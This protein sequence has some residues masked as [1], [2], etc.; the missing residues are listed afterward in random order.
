MAVQ[1]WIRAARGWIRA[2]TGIA[3]SWTIPPRAMALD[4]DV[5]ARRRTWTVGFAQATGHRA[6]T[7]VSG[8]GYSRGRS[9][10]PREPWKPCPYRDST[11]G[12]PD[13][14]ASATGVHLPATERPAM[15]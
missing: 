9:V 14:G 5:Q 12:C 15:S 6:G 7:D 8:A 1:G 3:G 2:C 11:A 10:A 4:P 13:L